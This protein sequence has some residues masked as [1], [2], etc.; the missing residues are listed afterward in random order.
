MIQELFQYEEGGVWLKYNRH[1]NNGTTERA[2]EVPIAEY[3]HGLMLSLG[4]PIIE[5]GAVLPYFSRGWSHRILDPIDTHATDKASLFSVNYGGQAVISISTIEHVDDGRYGLPLEGKTPLDAYFKIQGESQYFLITIPYGWE[6]GRLEV[7]PLQ[8]YL[9]GRPE[10]INVLTLSRFDEMNWRSNLPL[11]T[12][13]RSA[14]SIIISEKGGFLL[15][16]TDRV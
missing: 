14:N 8:K 7:G 1:Q 16:E 11:R 4:I 10:G 5:V 13:G 15:K 12:Y 9:L 6:Q 3:W 2:V